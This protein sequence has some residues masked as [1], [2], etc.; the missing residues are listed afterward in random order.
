ME[1]DKLQIADIRSRIYEVRR[2]RVMLDVDL[3]RLYQVET[4]VLKQAVRRNPDRFPEDFMLRLTKEESNQLIH[5]GVSQNVIPSGYN[6]GG[7]NIFAFTEHGVL[8]LAYVLRSQVAIQMGHAVVRTFVAMRESLNKALNTNLQM[9]SI[10]AELANQRQ[11]IED[12][13]RDQ[14]DTN[15][16][17]QAQLDAIS[18]SLAE[19]QSEVT[20]QPSAHTV[21]EGFGRR[22]QQDR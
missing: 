15:A 16:D 22:R 19:L 2:V 9:E 13:L 17:V 3:A 4:R 7:S 6:P 21:V 14:N 18:Q 20:R 5:I 11:Y 8:A 10:R 12:I 1:R